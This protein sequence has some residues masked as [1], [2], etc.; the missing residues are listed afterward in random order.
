MYRQLENEA[1]MLH[2]R[3]E[4]EE[5][6]QMENYPMLRFYV[7]ENLEVPFVSYRDA[8]IENHPELSPN[9]AAEIAGAL[10][11]TQC[12]DQYAAM[13][14]RQEDVACPDWLWSLFD[15]VLLAYET[16]PTPQSIL[17]DLSGN[18]A[19]LAD[20]HLLDTHRISFEHPLG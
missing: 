8:L 19:L 20:A 15:A 3:P 12:R 5:Q 1:V 13:T 4:I 18:R 10:C 16:M 17:I 7:D 11:W 14:N 2:Q 6:H 9:R